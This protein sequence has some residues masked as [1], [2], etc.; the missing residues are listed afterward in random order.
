MDIPASVTEIGM[1]AFFSCENL[2]D[3]TLHEGLTDIAGDAF[4]GCRNLARIV[5]PDSVNYI[6]SSAFTKAWD[7][8]PTILDV[9]KGSYAEQYGTQNR[10]TIEYK[11]ENP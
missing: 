5:I 2:K 1:G 9:S 3:V 10:C 11:D 6:G 4:S 7:Q 8:D